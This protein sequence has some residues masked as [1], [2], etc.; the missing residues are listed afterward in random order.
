MRGTFF[1]QHPSPP[2][3]ECNRG[4]HKTID[5]RPADVAIIKAGSKTAYGHEAKLKSNVKRVLRQATTV[6]LIQRMLKEAV[7]RNLLLALLHPCI[8][9]LAPVT[10]I[11]CPGN[12]GSDLLERMDHRGLIEGWQPPASAEAPHQV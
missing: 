1:A 2:D 3:I 9:Q 7:H 8:D 12:I 4:A 10:G 5:G 6:E 11:G